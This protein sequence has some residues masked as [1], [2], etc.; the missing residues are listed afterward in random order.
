MPQIQRRV[1][2]IS[3]SPSIARPT[4]KTGCVNLFIT[5]ACNL[6]HFKL[7][8][9]SPCDFKV[10]ARWLSALIPQHLTAA[11]ARVCVCVSPPSANRHHFNLTNPYEDISCT[12]RLLL[13]TLLAY[14]NFKLA[15]MCAR[16]RACVRRNIPTAAFSKLPGEARTLSNWHRSSITG[17]ADK[18]L[19]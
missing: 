7:A 5:S 18:H 9:L 4:V 1:L 15:C 16:V 8:I 19:R 12:L 17:R 3:V 14:L 6:F 13:F 10:A 2:N 11:R